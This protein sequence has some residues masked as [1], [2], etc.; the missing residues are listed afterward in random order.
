MN[1]TCRAIKEEFRSNSATCER[2][3]T[4]LHLISNKVRFRIVCLLAQGE[5]CVHDI[6][7]IVNE[8]KLSNISQQLAILRLGGI[9]QK[10]RDD[11][12]VLYVIKDERVRRLIEF[13]CH[14]YL[15]KESKA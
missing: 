14:Q 10:R 2:V 15:K 11:K 6:M 3:V 7:R 4:L 1:S 9:V 13:L 12:R 5:F 8:G